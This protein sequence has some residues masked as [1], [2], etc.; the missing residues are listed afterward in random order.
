[1]NKEK[2]WFSVEPIFEVRD[3]WVGFFVDPAKQKLYFLPVPMLGLVFTW[4][5]D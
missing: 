4:K 2:L 3:L 1:M 5:K